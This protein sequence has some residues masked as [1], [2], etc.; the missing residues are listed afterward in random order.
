MRLAGFAASALDQ[1]LCLLDSPVVRLS[2]RISNAIPGF[3]KTG[4]RSALETTHETGFCVQLQTE[5]GIVAQLEI[6]LACSTPLDTGWMIQGTQGGFGQGAES[7]TEPDG[8][9]YQVPVDVE[10]IDPYA[11]LEAR[12]RGD[13]STLVPGVVSSIQHEVVV[14][15]FLEAIRIAADAG[16]VIDVSIGSSECDC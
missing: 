15:E 14:A 2:A 1:L 12:L 11:E 13:R 3:G 5:S 7:R 4:N 10:P 9:V 6:D 16:N 8:E